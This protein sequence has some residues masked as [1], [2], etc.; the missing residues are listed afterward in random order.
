MSSDYW[1]APAVFL[2]DTAFSLYIFALALRFLL[3]W[4][5]ADHLNPLSRFL[6]RITHPPL[7]WF[8]RFIPPVGRIDTATLVLLMG[9]QILAG[10][11]VFLVQGA[12]P[13]LGAL[14]V[15]A[16]A[17]LLELVLNIY[18]YS[19]I[20]RAVLSWFGPIRYNPAVALV[21]SLTEPLLEASRRWLPATGGIDLS[22]ILPLVGIQL[23]KM[24]VLPPLEQ[25]AAALS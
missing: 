10:F 12:S 15:W 5:G 11:L 21:Y 3:Q 19:I 20:I 2:I 14:S 23:V 1:V 22:P 16:V 24:L 13:S 8:R 18:F 17:Q 25:L 7:K 4:C 9:L 6:I